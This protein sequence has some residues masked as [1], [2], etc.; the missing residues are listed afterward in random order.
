VSLG[1]KMRSTSPKGHLHDPVSL[2]H[3]ASA[4]N[5]SLAAHSA[6][7]QHSSDSDSDHH[8]SSH[9]HHNSRSSYRNHGSKSSMY[10]PPFGNSSDVTP[11]T[12]M[13]LSVKPSGQNS[14]NNNNHHHLRNERNESILKARG[15][16]VSQ[17]LKSVRA[18][19]LSP[20]VGQNPPPSFEESLN[21]TLGLMGMGMN[22]SSLLSN[23][24]GSMKPSDLMAAA[25]AQ[26]FLSSMTAGLQ[27]QQQQH[28][29]Q[30]SSGPA[31]SGSGGSLSP[32][33]SNG[34]LSNSHQNDSRSNNSN[35]HHHHHHS[36][37]NN[38]RESPHNNNMRHRQNDMESRGGAIN[39][40][41]EQPSNNKKVSQGTKR[42]WNPLPAPV[43]MATQLVN[44]ATGKA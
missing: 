32:G 25:A 8:S 21:Q 30:S 18:S 39:T 9:N 22:M 40:K 1:L 5:L 13:D 41:Q 10:S 17:A 24:G 19:T 31:S 44:P 12:V 11:T 43:A 7:Q 6:P 27:Q 16:T 35:Q 38:S 29:K 23:L 42:S 3:S 36:N 33:Q 4:L 37:A 26:Q 15:I 34:G 2:L 14:S 20:K 28:M